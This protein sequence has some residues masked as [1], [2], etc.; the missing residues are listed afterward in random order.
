MEVLD[1]DRKLVSPEVQVPF[2]LN[3]LSTVF[4]KESVVDVLKKSF[5]IDKL[6]D[7]EKNPLLFLKLSKFYKN[8]VDYMARLQKRKSVKPYSIPQHRR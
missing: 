5:P 6:E 1:E 3:G 2:I 7:F 4:G 8:E